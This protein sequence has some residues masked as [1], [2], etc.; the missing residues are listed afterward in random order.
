MNYF[1]LRVDIFPEVQV[2]IDYVKSVSPSCAWCYEG[3]DDNPHMH[4]YIETNMKHDAF[5]K[6][7]KVRLPP[8]AGNKMYSLAGLD[9]RY[10]ADWM[11]YL[12]KEGKVHWQNVP[13]AIIDKAFAD[14]LAKVA[15]MK[16][17]KDKKKKENVLDTLLNEHKCLRYEVQTSCCDEAC[18][19]YT[20][21]EHHLVNQLPIRRNQLGLYFDTMLARLTRQHCPHDAHSVVSTMYPQYR[22][23]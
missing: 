7:L 9:G 15:D 10:P 13:Q 18:I 5:R 14:N 21:T 20:I 3:T 12:V 17:T 8:A 4:W 11:A 6:Q 16:K 1:K 19:E 2:L 23:P 22:R